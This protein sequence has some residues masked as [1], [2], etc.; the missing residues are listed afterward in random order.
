MQ[1]I[2]PMSGAGARFSR[3]GYASPKPLIEVD[4]KPMIEHVV[5]MF[6]GATDFLF[7]CSR[8]HMETTP[9]ENVLRALVPQAT[10]AAIEPHKRGPVHAVLA[11][12]EYIRDDSPVIVSYCDFSADWDFERFRAAVA[13]NHC[14][15]CVT[16]YRGFHP[17][18]LGPNLYA[19]I[20]HQEDRL[21]EIR[22]KH[23]FTGN[24]MQ[25]FASAGSYYMRSGRLLKHYFARAIEEDLNTNGEYYASMPFNLLVAEGLDV[26]IYELDRFLQW[27]T[28]ED[29]EEYLGWSEYFR[30]YEDW[31]PSGDPLPGVNLLPAAGRGVRFQKEGYRQPKP[32]IPVGGVPMIRRAAATLPPAERWIT[33]SRKEE[34]AELIQALRQEGIERVDSIQIEADTE[35]QLCSCLLARE[36]II[37]DEPLAIFPCDAALIYDGN[38]FRCL[39]LSGDADCIV[40]TFR[41]HPHANRHP[42]QYGWA[43]RGCSCRRARAD[44]RGDLQ[45]STA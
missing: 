44:P 1:V 11:A 30:R 38:A 5:G 23:C 10:I 19:Y 29:L 9:M 35:G 20:R 3:K 6:P 36:H 2:I 25:E 41:N 21:V 28:P 15:G 45:T 43:A 16:A 42:Q 13:G 37:P 12:Q 39:A 22:E 32:F 7:I 4:G 31:R 34:A 33:V 14:D 26:R 40:W 17:H 8:V 24:R 27:G 18:S